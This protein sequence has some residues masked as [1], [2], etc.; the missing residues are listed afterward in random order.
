MKIVHVSHLYHPS[1]GGVQF[2][3]KNVSER[4]VKNY[5][6][7]VTLVTTNS[8]YGPERK[9]FKKVEPAE[10]II[11]GVKVIR[12]SYIRW[13]IKL[14]A[15]AFKVLNRLT[16]KVPDRMLLMKYGPVSIAMKRYLMNSDA[17]AFCASAANYWYMQL[18]LWRKCNFFYF[19]SIHL[20][21]DESK[22]VLN[23][24]QLHSINASKLYLANTNYE[25]RRLVQ[26]GV[27]S[28]KIVVLGVGV[29]PD[30]FKINSVTVDKFKKELGLHN[31]CLVIGYVGRIERTKSILVL[32]KGFEKIAKDNAHIYLLIA[33][34]GD[35]YAAEL[36]AYCNKLSANINGRIKWKINFPV[37]EKAALFNALDIL[38]L[39]SS[40]ESFGI[41]FLEAW[42]CKKPVIGT[43]TGAVKDVIEKNADGLIM[44]ID[45][46]E[47]LSNKLIMLIEDKGMRES[48]GKKGYEKVINNYTWDIITS[49]LRQC[50]LDGPEK[51][52]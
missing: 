30:I 10:E 15:F 25:K 44:E 50:Y 35:E 20:S 34:S 9:V 6:D 43:A 39:P 13:H 31:N 7:D 24:T 42:I 18:P 19:G 32:I 47:S 8:L 28:E 41:V 14:F 23:K 5:G 37:Q 51:L 11:N 48:M 33:G 22:P 1:Q 36:K 49:R 46:V 12:F 45:D 27:K 16:I 26:A 4:L 40:N 21:E 2:W 52:N 29:D 38:V 3:F 17:D